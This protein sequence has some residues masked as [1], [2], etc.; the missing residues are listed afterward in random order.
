MD[1]RRSQV[2]N[3]LFRCENGQL[4]RLCPDRAIGLEELAE[5]L[6]QDEGPKLALGDGGRLCRRPVR[7]CF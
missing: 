3:A 5:E 7:C 4:T 6:R 2:Y 1:A